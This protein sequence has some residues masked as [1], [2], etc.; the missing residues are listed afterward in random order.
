MNI[1]YSKLNEQI[2]K[3]AWS[4]AKFILDKEQAQQ[5]IQEKVER[6]KANILARS[7]ESS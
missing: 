1:D 7:K 3:Q 6:A 5:L 4:T 2:V